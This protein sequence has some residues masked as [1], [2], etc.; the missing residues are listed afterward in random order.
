MASSVSLATIRTRIRRLAD[1]EDTD[2][3]A[4]DAVLNEIINSSYKELIDVLRSCFGHEY[5]RKSFTITTDTSD[6]YALPDDFLSLLWVEME[7]QTGLAVRL[8]PFSIH[9]AASYSNTNSSYPLAYRVGRHDPGGHAK[10]VRGIEIRP[11]VSGYTLTLWYV[12]IPDSLDNDNDTFDS[13]NGWEDYI[14][15]D[16]VAQ[17]LAKEESD[18]SFAVRKKAEVEMR[19]RSLAGST[20]QGFPDTVGDVQGNRWGLY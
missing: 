14:V 4:S 6:T 2:D 18:P 8:H 1:M 17:L 9:N 10:P 16:G 13:V 7:A 19:I 12:P 5:D 15:W 11:P 20:D 3:L